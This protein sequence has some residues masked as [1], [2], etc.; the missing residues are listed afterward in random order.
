MN[1]K[2]KKQHVDGWLDRNGKIYLCKFNHHNEKE[3][4]LMKEY[5]LNNTPEYLGWIK[6]HS[7]GVWFFEADHFHN[8]QYVK[9]T[10]KQKNWLFDHN[11]EVD[12]FFPPKIK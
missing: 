3:I 12:I 8:R 1:D 11:Y 2:N 4:E 9:V 7:A 10:K 5:K 6:I